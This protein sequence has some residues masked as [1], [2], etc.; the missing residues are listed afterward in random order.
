MSKQLQEHQL[1]DKEEVNET[2]DQHKPE[3]TV[4]LVASSTK[5]HKAS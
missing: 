2:D 5:G 1:K 4:S 3:N